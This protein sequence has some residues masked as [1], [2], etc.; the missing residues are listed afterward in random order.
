LRYADAAQH[1]QKAAALTPSGHSAE[2]ADYL[3]RQAIALYR[4]GDERGDNMALL[5]SVEILRLVLGYRTR[6]QVPLQW[7]ATE[8][9]LGVALSTL[10]VSGTPRGEAGADYRA[11]MQEFP[12]DQV[13]LDW[14]YKPGI[15]YA[16]PGS[17][18]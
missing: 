3:D 10:W 13:L 6:D 18:A 12:R 5:R 14:A 15:Y 1:F 4:E 16:A 17:V 9:N 8:N 7:A 11:P 2:T